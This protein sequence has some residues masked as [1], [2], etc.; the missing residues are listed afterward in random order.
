MGIDTAIRLLVDVLLYGAPGSG[1][2][3]QPVHA[4]FGVKTV[5]TTFL[6]LSL[7]LLRFVP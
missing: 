3:E 1:Y 2:A 6:A 4:I 7:H 5:G